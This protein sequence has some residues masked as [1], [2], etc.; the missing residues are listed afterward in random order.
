MFSRWA[1]S[2]HSDDGLHAGSIAKEKSRE[3]AA[4]T[5]GLSGLAVD[6]NAPSFVFSAGY[7]HEVE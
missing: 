7:S 1:A 2:E 3:V 6:A 4:F 5:K